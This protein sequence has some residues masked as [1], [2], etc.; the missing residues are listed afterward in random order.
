MAICRSQ[1]H[2]IQGFTL[3][4]LLVVVSVIAVLAALLMPSIKMVRVAAQSAGCLSHLRQLGMGLLAYAEDNRVLPP[5]N[6]QLLNVNYP[7]GRAW[8]LTQ[9]ATYLES[10]KAGSDGNAA[11]DVLKCPG[12]RRI[13]TGADSAFLNTIEYMHCEWISNGDSNFSSFVRLWSSYA[14]ND[15]VFVEGRRRVPENIAMIWDSWRMKP[16]YGWTLPGWARH[17]KQ[18]NVLFGDGHCGGITSPFME[19]GQPWDLSWW[20]GNGTWKWG[21]VICVGPDYPAPYADS[22]LPPWKCD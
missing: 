10:E 9:A 5:L 8:A 17:A 13:V 3:L 1:T 12:D 14:A 20:M 6:I 18:T 4:E 7:E 22:R 11:M 19:Y 16:Q 15:T 2:R 21:S